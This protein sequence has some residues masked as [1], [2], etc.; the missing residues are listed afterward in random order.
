MTAIER[1]AQ[2]QFGH[3]A[4]GDERR[5]RRAVEMAA[6]AALRPAG[7]VSQVFVGSAERE[8]AFRFLENPGVRADALLQAV[9]LRTVQ[10][11]ERHEKV[12]VPIDGSS[13]TL[14]DHAGSK[15][16]GGVGAWNKGARGVQVMT[17]LAVGL[18]GR[19]IGV[20]SQRYWTREGRSTG[21]GR[22]ARLDSEN[23]FW[24]ELLEEVHGDFAEASEATPWFQ[25]DRGADCWPVLQLGVELGALMTVRATHDRNLE[26]D[27]HLWATLRRAPIRGHK[28]LLLPSRGPR[29]RK[30]RTGKKR[31]SYLTKPRRKRTAHLVI[32]AAQVGLVCA[33]SSKK[34]IVVPIHAVYVRERRA[35][36]DNKVEWMLLTTHPIR[37]R[38]DVLAVVDAYALRW[39]IEDFHRAWKDGLCGI[40]RTQLRS[41]EAIFKWATLLATVATR[42]MRLTHLARETPDVLATTEFTTY[43]LQ[44][45][46]AQRQPKGVRFDVIPTLT[47]SQAVRW[48][49]DVVGYTGPWNGPPGATL[50]GR[51]LEL[52]VLTARGIENV[53]KMR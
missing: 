1:W 39:R 28:A 43:E 40:E 33:V 19:A 46:I 44:A 18:D 35:T 32:R 12:I 24:R 29:Q 34:T 48:M 16:L 15:D 27:G 30:K 7:V 5:T 53:E 42:A 10:D 52:T 11:C 2:D 21:V 23:R 50:V 45:I 22:R 31:V 26:P 14:A 9:R 25:M 3:A 20:C 6:Q 51:G 13:L 41:K 8:G 38:R 49:V 17:A 36:G 37:R 47:L 4:L